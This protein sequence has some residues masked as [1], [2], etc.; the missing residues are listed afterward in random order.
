MRIV[1]M[2]RGLLLAILVLLLTGSICLEAQSWKVESTYVLDDIVL[3]GFLATHLGLQ[4]V[5]DHGVDL[6][7]NGS[8]HRTPEPPG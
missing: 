5:D 8:D 3:S 2:R 4:G 6:G 1:L 7:G